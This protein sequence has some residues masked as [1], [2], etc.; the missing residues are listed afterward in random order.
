MADLLAASALEGL[1]YWCPSMAFIDPLRHRRRYLLRAALGL[2]GCIL[3]ALLLSPLGQDQWALPRRLIMGLFVTALAYLCARI[4]LAGAAYCA[5]LAEVAAQAVHEL[6]M[7]LQGLLFGRTTLPWR[8]YWWVEVLFSCLVYLVLRF[9]VARWLPY[10]GRYDPGL[11]Q[12][13]SGGL[14]ALLFAVLFELLRQGVGVATWN[15]AIVLP[16]VLGQF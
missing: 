3:M 14:L 2:A 15:D 11:L 8:Q 12:L 13:I 10:E 7:A 4:S 5:V 9:T 16:A 6:W 1:L